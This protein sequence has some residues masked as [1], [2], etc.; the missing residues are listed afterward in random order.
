MSSGK[1]CRMIQMIPGKIGRRLVWAATDG[2][3]V[4]ATAATA[5]VRGAVAA[6]GAA[7]SVGLDRRGAPHQ[8]AGVGIWK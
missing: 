7:A 3:A 2:T 5:G 8:H 1:C 4:S 6:D